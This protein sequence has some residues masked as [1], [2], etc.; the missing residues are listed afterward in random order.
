[1]KRVEWMVGA[2]VLVW[3]AAAALL[4]TR[5]GLEVL[6]GMMGPLVVASGAWVLTERTYKRN[7]SGVTGLLMAAFVGKMLFFGAYVAVAIVIL[8][9]RPVPFVVSFTAY[10][11]ALQVTEA[12]WLRRLLANRQTT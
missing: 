2:S 3:L 12:I 10:F 9:V 7:P 4:G 11:V 6:L 8:A 5:T 1:M